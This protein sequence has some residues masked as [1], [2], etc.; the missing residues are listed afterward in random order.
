MFLVAGV[1]FSARWYLARLEPF[2]LFPRPFYTSSF[3][4]RRKLT[5][6]GVV[7]PRALTDY[8]IPL[9]RFPGASLLSRSASFE[10]RSEGAAPSVPFI[11]PAPPRHRTNIATPDNLSPPFSF[12]FHRGEVAPLSIESRSRHLFPIPFS[13]W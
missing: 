1:K 4:A 11:G 2:L 13:E 12:L 7:H 3:P 5:I 10:C 9:S 8:P 6:V